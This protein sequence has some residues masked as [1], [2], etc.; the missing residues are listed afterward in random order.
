MGISVRPEPP[1][2]P[3]NIMSGAIER[4][5]ADALPAAPKGP[6]PTEYQRTP[7]PFKQSSPAIPRVLE[8]Q[9]GFIDTLTQLV[10]RPGSLEAL[11]HVSVASGGEFNPRGQKITISGAVSP[12]YAVL[13]KSVAPNTRFTLAHEWA[14]LLAH[15]KDEIMKAFMA[16]APLPKR[17]NIP[18]RYKKFYGGWADVYGADFKLDSTGKV[19]MVVDTSRTPNLNRQ[20]IG[21]EAFADMF[22]TQ[23]GTRFRDAAGEPTIDQSYSYPFTPQFSG[24]MRQNMVDSLITALL[25][26]L[27]L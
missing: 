10:G 2:K 18:Q 15:N 17:L 19:Q 5:R 7:I 12:E 21:N 24:R 27:K 23:L 6:A 9:R 16:A 13:P 4:L 20:Y 1:K 11:P 22:A 25:P 8:W 3:R 26:R 14:H